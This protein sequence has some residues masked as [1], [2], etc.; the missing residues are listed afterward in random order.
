M[1]D[2]M[3]CKPHKFIWNTLRFLENEKKKKKHATGINNNIGF[4]WQENEDI[5]QRYE[6]Y[7]AFM[8]RNISYETITICYK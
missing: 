3:L 5:E 4:L 7:N 8:Y 6:S 1:V 2:E